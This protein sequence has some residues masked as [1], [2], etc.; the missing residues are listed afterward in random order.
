LTWTPDGESIIFSMSTPGRAVSWPIDMPSTPR[1]AN[2]TQAPRIVESL[3]YRADRRGFTN[4]G[5]AT[6]V[7]IVPAEGGTPRQL[8]KGDRDFGGFQLTPDGRSIVYT[9]NAEDER[10]YRQ[11]DIYILN[12]ETGVE[13]QLTDRSGPDGDPAV[14]PDGRWVA[15]LGYDYTTDTY[16]DDELYVMAIDGSG[17]LPAREC[18]RAPERLPR[19]LRRRVASRRGRAD[20]GRPHHRQRRA[21]TAQHVRRQ[22]RRRPRRR[23]RGREAG[24]PLRAPQQAARDD[25]DRARP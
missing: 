23:T 6:H 16:I 12:L 19:A 24:A 20:Q 13:R 9:V 2:W 11:S 18:G 25:H 3:V 7:F 8:T 5:G 22:R 1:G 17:R 21:G 10:Q 4:P 14:S 15:Y